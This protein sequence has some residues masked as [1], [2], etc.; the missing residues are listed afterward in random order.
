MCR[1]A[2]IAFPCKG[3][4]DRYL[5]LGELYDESLKKD[6]NKLLEFRKDLQ[7]L[8]PF[9]YSF[10]KRK[11]YS[12]EDLESFRKK[13]KLTSRIVS[14][15]FFEDNSSLTFRT[16]VLYDLTCQVRIF[17]TN[18]LR[19]VYKQ[20]NDSICMILP[21]QDPI[22]R[23]KLLYDAVVYGPM[24]FAVTGDKQ[25]ENLDTTGTLMS[26]YLQS[27]GVPQDRII[28]IPNN[29][30][31]DCILEG[32]E[33]VN[34]AVTDSYTL[35]LSCIKEDISSLCRWKRRYLHGSDIRFFSFY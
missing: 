32:I 14:V 28:K 19:P 7:F 17:L 12:N 6:N 2:L 4:K 24:F 9:K 13:Y 11:C 34:L 10:K 35:F 3:K 20:K 27:C 1:W 5:V 16:P 18:F 26:R 30:V 21:Y 31:P 33:I 15:G 22:Q 8:Y 23:G 29:D 25:G